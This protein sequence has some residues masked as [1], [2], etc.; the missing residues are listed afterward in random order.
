MMKARG[1]SPA[2]NDK[3]L[4]RPGYTDMKK[5]GEESHKGQLLGGTIVSSKYG[6]LTWKKG[7]KG[8]KET[9]RDGTG[10]RKERVRRQGRPRTDGTRLHGRGTI[11][12]P[13]V[14]NQN[15]H[16]HPGENLAYTPA[17]KPGVRNRRKYKG[18]N[19]GE[20]MVPGSTKG[21][22]KSARVPSS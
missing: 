16:G 9:N 3:K 14:R 13:K 19:S 2:K 1:G 22:R 20:G 4:R 8:G 18:A 7:F 6:G 21:I 15:R 11:T 5:K 10:G 12:G 17:Q